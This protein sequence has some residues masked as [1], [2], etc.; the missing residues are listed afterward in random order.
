MSS[1][2][3]HIHR[4]HGVSNTTVGILNLAAAKHGFDYSQVQVCIISE[5]SADLK[6]TV[7]SRCQFLYSPNIGWV[8]LHSVGSYT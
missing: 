8:A 3:S 2:Q 1:V 5:Q 6:T 4:V 7:A